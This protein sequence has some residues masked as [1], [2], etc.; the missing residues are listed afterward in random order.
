MAAARSGRV[1]DVAEWL[2]DPKHSGGGACCKNEAPETQPALSQ[3]LALAIYHLSLPRVEV[4]GL[5]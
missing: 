3:V 2:R 4:F 5:G 1:T